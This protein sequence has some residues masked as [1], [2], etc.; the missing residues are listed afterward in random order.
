MYINLTLIVELIGTVAFAAS[1][2]MV[3]IRKKMDILGVCVLALCVAIGGGVIRD[4]IL[5]STPPVT[6]QNPIYA[7]F[8]ISIAIILFI[9]KVRRFVS[10]HDYSYG[11]GMFWMDS[12]GLGVFTAI[13]VQ[14]C[15][16]TV[17]EAGV[18]LAVFVGVMTG[19]GGGVL[20][21]VLA[22]D[23]PYIFVKHFYASASIIGALVCTLM[24][25]YFFSGLC[26]LVCAAVVILLRFLAAR[27]RWS[28]PKAEDIPD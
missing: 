20:R 15:F 17:P 1:G 2:A 21:D 24:W 28:L 16:E 26:I 5:G 27:Y 6:F 19:V 9:P 4:I 18:F 25:K 22:G 8:A 14:R 11:L 10:H 7:I 13:G 23:M 3:G 12:I